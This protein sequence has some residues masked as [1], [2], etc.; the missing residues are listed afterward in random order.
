MS[1]RIAVVTGA[2][3]GIGAEIAL[4][5]AKAGFHPL[6]LARR[7]DKL[8]EVAARI[9]GAGGTAHAEVL[10]VTAPGA[11]RKALAAAT[12]LGTPEVL[13]NNAGKGTYGLFREIPAEEL[14]S[15]IDL[16]VRALVELTSV[17]LPAMVE[18]RR[19]HVLNVAS[20]AAFQG[21]PYQAV[22]GATKAFVVSFTD[23][24]A[25]ELRGTGV[26]VTALCPGPTRTEFLEL[27]AFEDKGMIVP[28]IALMSA[29]RVADVGVRAMLR[30]KTVAIAGVTNKLG[31]LG[32]KLAPRGLAARVAGFIFKPRRAPR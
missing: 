3:T 22:Y 16:N 5:L 6:L 8:R 9:E 26:S 15:Q 10:D 7:A 11:A 32:S 23:A 14:V 21:V 17:F 29:Q 1:A 25:V 13:V 30:R 18:R 24:L 27:A 4:R 19:G 2:S 20:T 28:R 12:A 31:T